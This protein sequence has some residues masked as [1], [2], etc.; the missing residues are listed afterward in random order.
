M[1]LSKIYHE[2]AS[3]NSPIHVEHGL[4]LPYFTL[5]TIYHTTM[6][7]QEMKGT[8]HI[9]YPQTMLNPEGDKEYPGVRCTVK[10]LPYASTR[11]G[12]SGLY[13]GE[14]D[15]VSKLPDGEGILYCHGGKY[16]EGEWRLGRFLLEDPTKSSQY[17]ESTQDACDSSACSSLSVSITGRLSSSINTHPKTKIK[18]PKNLYVIKSGPSNMTTR[19]NGSVEVTK[20]EPIIPQVESTEDLDD[21]TE[22]DDINTGIRA[23]NRTKLI[24]FA[25]FIFKVKRPLKRRL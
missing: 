17:S 24:S 2:K 6:L 7:C 12:L 22:K 8:V 5:I 10:S 21:E 16:L 15:V 9:K 13:C 23:V 4:T 18:I 3:F 20:R 11:L 19:D 14:M 25:P 1:N